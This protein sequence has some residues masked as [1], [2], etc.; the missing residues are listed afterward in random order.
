MFDGPVGPDLTIPDS[1]IRLTTAVH[2]FRCPD[3][4]AKKLS[5]EK[6]FKTS[7]SSHV[8]T[9]ALVKEVSR[10][11]FGAHARSRAMLK[12]N[13]SIQ[14]KPYSC[15]LDLLRIQSLGDAH[16]PTR[17]EMSLRSPFPKQPFPM[18]Q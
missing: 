17:P 9:K 18:L 8:E 14:G 10:I 12:P 2:R 7:S 3:I 16:R 1:L 11:L 15:H 13:Y 5:Y 6:S 4:G